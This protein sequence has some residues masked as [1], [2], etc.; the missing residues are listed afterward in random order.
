LE[1]TVIGQTGKDKPKAEGART[2]RERKGSRRVRRLLAPGILLLL[3]LGIYLA[4]QFP[5][6]RD[7][8]LSYALNAANQAGYSITYERTTGNV[9][10]S[11]GLKNATVVGRGIDVKLET[12]S[13]RYFLPSLLTGE[14][15]LDIN[16]NGL[17][18][19]VD[20]NPPRTPG[21]PGTSVTARPEPSGGG[22][23]ALPIRVRLR[24]VNVQDIAVAASDVPFTLPNFSVS[25]L[26]VQNRGEV[27]HVVTSVATEEGS[28]NVEGDVR[29]EPFSITA[30][31][32]RAD[33]TIAKHWYPDIL[34]G[35]ATGT[36][37]VENGEVTVAAEVA[38][39]AIAFLDG[40][41]TDISGPATMQDFK[42]NGNLTAKT[43]GG[44]LTATIGVDIL[45]ERWYGEGT[46]DNLDFKEVALWLAKNRLPIDLSTW[47]I[48]GTLQTKVNAEGWLD[49]IV[50]GT[51]T[52]D[53]EIAT[54]PLEN[55]NASYGV[56]IKEGLADVDVDVAGL[57]AQGQLNAE[58]FTEGR[59]VVFNLTTSGSK[60]LPTVAANAS[61]DLRSGVDGTNG[62]TQIDLSGEFLGREIAASI[63]GIINIDGWQNTLTGTTSQDETL[64]GAFVL[65]TELEGQINGGDIKIPGA[66]PL[67]LSLAANG[68]PA[69]LP[70]TL[71]LESPTPFTWSIAGVDVP[72]ND[73]EITGRLEAIVLKELQG[74]I[75]TLNLQGETW[76]TG[77][78]ANVTFSLAETPLSGRVTGTLAASN[79]RVTIENRVVNGQA[80]IQ[81]GTL[82]TSGVTLQPI[83]GTATFAFDDTL[84]AS[85]DSPTLIANYDGTTLT[86]NLNQIELAAFGQD[87]EATGTASLSPQQALQT[88]NV[89][90]E[91]SSP[92]ANLDIQG[93]GGQL[94]ITG[95]SSQLGTPL[96][97]QSSVNLPEQTFSLNGTLNDLTLDGSGNF[98]E[99]LQATID[100]T[101]GEDGM[102]LNVTGT[103][104]SPQL[105]LQ[106]SLPA[107]SLEPILRVPLAGTVTADLSRS[108]SEY[109]GTV[110]LDGEVS[111]IPINARVVGNGADLQLEGTATAYGQE[112]QLRGAVQ[113]DI[114]VTAQ[115]EIGSVTV[116]RDETGF[117]LS[118]SGTTPTLNAA[119][120]EIAPQ[121][122]QVSG[123]ISDIAVTLGDSQLDIQQ[124]GGLVV[125]G[126]LQQSVRRG[127]AEILLDASA[128][129]RPANQTSSIDGTLTLVT[130]SGQTILP[131]SGSLEN[132][133]L[134]GAVAAKE[135]ATLAGVSVPLAGDVSLNG[136][137]SL[138]GETRYDVT[139]VWQANGQTLNVS[140]QGTGADVNATIQSDTLTASYTPRGF[141]INANNFDPAPF[142]E[143]IPVVGTL[144]GSLGQ[145][146]GQWLGSLDVA[147]S[148]P[149]ALS[150]RL[151]GQGETLAANFNYEQQGITASA[152]GA[153]LPT[154][155]LD[156]NAAYQDLATLQGS[157]DGS[158]SQPSLTGVVQTK[159][160]ANDAVGF[161][162]PAQSFEVTSGLGETL[163][164]LTNEGTN[165][166]V[167]RDTLTGQLILPFTLKEQAHT[168]QA[169][170]SGALINPNVVANVAGALVKGQITVAERQ[171]QSRLSV[172]PSPWL[173][174]RGLGIVN[175][176]P[177][178]VNANA[179]QNLEWNA[180]VFTTGTAR[181]LP[182]ELSASITGKATTYNG[183]GALRLNGENVELAVTGS[184]GSVQ[185]NADLRDGDLAA[186]QPL[187]SVP[188]NGVLNGQARVDTTQAQPFTFDV[189][190]IGDANGQTFELSSSLLPNAPLSVRGTYGT[191]IVSLE[192]QGAGQFAVKY[193]DP[194][195][196]R[197][198]LVEGVLT[199]EET[200]SLVAS[201][202]I[203]GESLTVDAQYLSSAREG[204][205]NVR[206]ANSSF[207]GSAV[208]QGEGVR[209]QSDVSLTPGAV[210]PLPLS[211]NVAVLL[212][213]GTVT[214]ERLETNTTLA[215]RDI[216]FLAS[217]VVLPETDIAGRFEI[218]GVDRTG[219]H[220][221]RR[222][223]GYALNLSQETFAIDATFTDGFEPLTVISRGGTEL[224]IGVPL[225][226]SGNVSWQAGLG[227]SGTGNLITSLSN[228]DATVDVIGSGPLNLSGQA[229]WN[230]APLATF[231]VMLP[232]NLMGALSGAVAI[233]AS[234]SVLGSAYTA[235]PTNLKSTL[236]LSGT[237]QQPVAQGS[238]Q[239][240]GGLTA[241]GRLEY[242]VSS[243]EWGRLELVG[244]GL[245]ILGTLTS[246][247]WNVDGAA[248]ELDVASFIP[249]L[250]TPKLSAIVRAEGKTGQPL[251]LQVQNL[252]LRSAQ[253]SL[254]GTISYNEVWQGDVQ[255]DVNL[256]DLNV[257]VG[258][259]G[260]LLGD[261]MLSGESL[262][263]NLQ[264]VGLKLQNSDAELGGRVIVS[265]QLS[266]PVVTA[267]LNG[268]GD[269]SGEVLF[270]LEPGQATTLSSN[271]RVGEFFTDL[272]I[273]LQD[274]TL[275][276]EG[277]LSFD[278]YRL[279]F[280]PAP[281]SSSFTLLGQEK[282]LGW[283]LTTNLAE[284]RVSV[285][286]DLANVLGNATGLVQLSASWQNLQGEN[287]LS[288]F[289]ENLSF[290]GV[291]LGDVEL[292]SVQGQTLSLQG[293][294]VDATFNTSDSSWT[295]NKLE[296]TF[297]TYR[298]SLSGSGR[299]SQAALA[300]TITGDVAG[301]RLNLPV[302]LNYHNDEFVLTSQGETLRGVVDI[303]ARGHL[304]NGW[305]GNVKLEN[306]NVQGFT[307]NFDGILTGAFAE[308]KLQA[309]LSASQGETSLSGSVDVSAS[310][311]TLEQV[312]TTPQLGQPLY[313]SGTVFPNTDLTLSTSENN[314]IH[315]SLQNNELVSDGNL[316]LDANAFRIV[317]ESIPGDGTGV[318]VSSKSAE[319][320]TLRT[321]LPR[322]SLSE[323]AATI[324]E[325]GVGF[326]GQD[327][328]SGWLVL[329][330]RDGLTAQAND[331]TYQSDVGTVTLTGRVSQENNWQGN[332]NL[333]WQGSG[334]E[335]AFVP[336]L[337]SLQD[338]TLQ[339][340]IS[341]TAIAGNV[342]SNAGTLQLNVNRETLESSL[343]GNLQLGS[344]Q[345]V[346]N[347]R[348]QSDL[349]PSGDITMND[350][351]LLEGL[352][353]SSQLVLGPQAVTGS[354]SLDV[355]DGQITFEGNYGLGTFSTA[356]F[357]Q[358]SSAQRVNVRLQ[359]IDVQS[360]P[361]LSNS[362]PNL[363]AV[364]AGRIQISGGQV[365][366]RILSPE[367]QVEDKRLPL[368]LDFNGS[369]RGVDVRGTL[370]RSRI[371]STIDTEHAE[372]LIVFDQFPL[373]STVEAAIGDTGVSGQLIGAARF[374]V[375]WGNL[376]D[377]TLDFAS[378]QIRLTQIGETERE[379]R[380]QVNFRYQGGALLIDQ[381]FFEGTGRWDASGQISP[382]VLDFRLSAREADFTPI[383]SLFPQL[384]SIGL[385]ASGSLEISAQ[386]SF[387]DP[388]VNVISP[389]LNVAVGGSSY[390]LQGARLSLA[391][392]EFST[393][394]Q[395]Q[396][397]S[398]I[399][400]N[401]TLVGN[402]ELL[403]GPIRPT[404]TLR[405]TGNA[406]VPTL[407]TINSLDAVI[408]AAPETG[409]QLNA[410]GLLGNPFTLT[411][412][413]APLDV[414]LQGTDLNLRAPENFLASSDSTVDIRVR[415]EEGIVISGSVDASQVNLDLNREI[416]DAASAALET[417]TATSST[418]ATT[419]TEN[420]PRN[421][422]L[423]QVRFE[424]VTI[425]APQQ[426]TFQENFGQAELGIDVV[427]SGTAA[428][429]ELSGE[430]QTL[431]GNFR[432]AGR[433]F[434]IERAVATFQR[435]Q[436][437]YPTVDIRA[438]ST[439]EKNQV[440]RGLNTNPD[441]SGQPVAEIIEP[442]GRTFQVYL[443]LKA[444]LV[445]RD[446]GGFAA[447]ITERS[448]ESNARL[449]QASSDTTAGGVRELT[450]D[451]LYSLLAFG[452]LQLAS[453][454]TGQG[455]VAESVAEG[456]VNTAIDLFIVSQ[457]QQQIGEALGVDLFEVRTTSLSSLFDGSESFGVAL[458]IGGYLQDDLFASYEIRTLD[459]D[460]DV[461]FANE[462]DLRYEFDRLELDLTGRLNVL[463]AESF[464]TVP[465]LSIGLGYA[466]TPLVRLETNADIS[467]AR[468]SVG[469]GVSLRW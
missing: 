415:Y 91:A 455:S 16:A 434:T 244:R 104:S 8:L 468:Q 190:A 337:S 157:V 27:L 46:S 4:P 237:L 113:P 241:S 420:A 62:G 256:Q 171:A 369:L 137:A 347:L 3:L 353:V 246:E 161:V 307:G 65:G 13:L 181:T 343:L 312:L 252:A 362:V 359:N 163:L 154:L 69:A 88:L 138:T 298:V 178:T 452:N 291:S 462:F 247:G 254:T 314:R 264:A 216:T 86:T 61:V 120:F 321:L 63:P 311:A 31:V 230:N 323:I 351:P 442:S 56:S 123:P 82:T 260:R 372:G 303:N 427:L 376:R 21:T 354:G 147:V 10:S 424:N 400:G 335:S 43:L 6:V 451:E 183:N 133:N 401:L 72:V 365:V 329:N 193:I 240:S 382:E 36:V 174:E 450:Q 278:E 51:A 457:L 238:I 431:R 299:G 30:N 32:L 130:P 108:G 139:G 19:D 17:S 223:E 219:F 395:L 377:A 29:L 222:D 48:S 106:G 437:I 345:L 422:F 458:R 370:G 146:Q 410:N 95:T 109:S 460:P 195:E 404:L 251:N 428:T 110:S 160:F 340:D 453:T 239:V 194:N 319:G 207:T 12:L 304:Q 444:E 227:F 90:V 37:T 1:Q 368:D 67:Q 316:I 419:T 103:P 445:A 125:S 185:A 280:A 266:A 361:V 386:G 463:R 292:T 180:E 425:R 52:G 440:L 126:D 391:G 76:L 117:V 338:V 201:G 330:I 249:Q 150:G 285:S 236:A 326:E 231:N 23:F 277:S 144:T 98:G 383:L 152:T 398:P 448:L 22:G 115:G 15:P 175:V 394:A 284:Q 136:N 406:A 77:E 418:S 158:F 331:L 387:A 92:I 296:P 399:T 397:V 114:E 275:Q 26:Q 375:P 41:V 315:L 429:P 112:L 122:W 443:N 39:G 407:G 35:T 346:S 348:Y 49:V 341:E 436:G 151:Y 447:T 142:F 412:S 89:D 226:Y 83:S 134:N 220:V 454:I 127:N 99:A 265:G 215:N 389:T 350:V 64:S 224:D 206:L 55:L 20:F 302:S 267:S 121:P 464:T 233:D 339:A 269:A 87:I 5:G 384:A 74:N 459:L 423:E 287:W 390:Q 197:P 282:L 378:E 322:A 135:L 271:L 85:L 148:S 196:A 44:D 438:Y 433:D 58:L 217:G 50:N 352:S 439:F 306:L 257:G 325:Q 192:P 53:G 165:L 235:A 153:L 327:K 379:S 100:A 243:T 308:P 408:T 310:Q 367:L 435:S 416:A 283:Q 388:Q 324:Q 221:V 385:G 355:G 276:G 218:T 446:G 177:V 38:D 469:F 191:M 208:P 176:Q 40:T 149:V 188:L 363:Q 203:A 211:A 461:A 421:R 356:L 232:P 258:L 209:L 449:E 45:G 301:E 184:G 96:D 261:V 155:A 111:S 465:E 344:G 200:I 204:T 417:P 132:L 156:V 272:D 255:T 441:D 250:D 332:L 295:V 93:G 75:G 336:W 210:V 101:R 145:Q 167:A 24:D 411:G 205:W 229:A 47:P 328:T 70:L 290:A 358:G 79:G 274:E 253:S 405:A 116:S 84:T 225:S 159:E 374:N 94:Q 403:L 279:V 187:V 373:E 294:K 199:L 60:L 202:Q 273:L 143:N 212:E 54:F 245:N 414:R 18:G 270:N 2:Q 317:L 57:L 259:E 242:G 168:L 97:I 413:L 320:L 456:A 293:G 182:L 68:N 162:L 432:F 268:S 7:W 141:E 179:N 396:G 334:G 164:T 286:G 169:D 166:R 131:V 318:S 300:G 71:R 309:T 288:G 14:L 313:V 172:D 198:A 129:Y 426:I 289:I 466:I 128:T 73:A 371:T 342:V 380:G 364:L 263:G 467:Q 333:H 107:Q 59:D 9:W 409:W 214:L 28:A 186:L 234:T 381:A 248:D 366:G 281:A 140:A 34:A 262:S 81:T 305:Q 430:A 228:L 105:T 11:I 213:N 189:R 173:A 25:N 124:D 393:Q 78:N 357:P 170:V 349:G 360:L 66:P 118:G 392:T 42:V 102:T 119:G 80:D 33:A 402:G 297:N